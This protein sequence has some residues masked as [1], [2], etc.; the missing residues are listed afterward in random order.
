MTGTEANWV[1]KRFSATE[2]SQRNVYILYAVVGLIVSCLVFLPAFGPRWG[3][4]EELGVLLVVSLMSVLMLTG[5]FA[6]R[7]QRACRRAAVE[8]WERV[9]LDDWDGAEAV[10]DGLMCD[11]IR[12]GSDRGQAFMLLAAVAEHKG[13]YGEA[14]QI[15]ETLLL[16]RIGDAL[17]L[18]QAQISLAAAKLR[19]QELTD[20]VNLLGRLEQLPMPRSLA[21]ALD[22]VRLYQQVFMGHYED[23]VEELEER[24]ALHRRHLS[25]HAA[26]GYGLMA[27][28][29]HHLGRSSEAARQ[30]SDATTL[31]PAER[32]VKEYE[33]LTPVLQAYPATRRPSALSDRRT[34]GDLKMK[35][36]G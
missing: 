24:R 6:G 25:T 29:L 18:Q 28:A 17:H 26:Y 8:A 7:R 32:L 15:Y 10:L 5:W 34:A 22:V 20:A 27:A 36:K 23:A 3:L 35:D 13:R 9:Q 21:A 19:N 33:M 4:P 12:S 11:G 14:A 2:P 31:I 30:W 16:R 1:E